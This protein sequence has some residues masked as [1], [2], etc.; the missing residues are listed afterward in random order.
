MRREVKEAKKKAAS[1]K[2][3]NRKTEAKAQLPE[4]GSRPIG[5]LTTAQEFNEARGTHHR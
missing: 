5:D 3:A 4:R 2:A 1:D